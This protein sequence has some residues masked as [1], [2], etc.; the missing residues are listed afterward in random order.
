MRAIGRPVAALNSS[1]A[2]GLDV[3]RRPDSF[4]AVHNAGNSRELAH[5]RLGAPP[6][7]APDNSKK[8]GARHR[9]VNG[10]ATFVRISAPFVAP[11]RGP[12]RRLCHWMHPFPSGPPCSRRVGGASLSW[13]LRVAERPCA[14][15]IV[16]TRLL[17]EGL[18]G[19]GWEDADACSPV[20]PTSSAHNDGCSSESRPRVVDNSKKRRAHP[21]EHSRL[22]G[23][24]TAPRRKPAD[25]WRGA[26]AARLS[27]GDR[28]RRRERLRAV[29]PPAP[30][31][32]STP[33]GDLADVA[34]WSGQPRLG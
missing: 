18:V 10:R 6:S 16:A 28:G 1:T 12:G 31:R 26:A 22:G 27:R 23:A 20:R 9:P 2:T 30:R 33:D 17:S 13:A 8:R 32:G 19:C 34:A 5:D 3:P 24:G 25:R 21:A 11:P 4:L 15:G 7:S 29:L 14:Q